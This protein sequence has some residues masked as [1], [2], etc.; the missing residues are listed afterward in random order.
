M[1]ENRRK[2]TVDSEACTIKLWINFPKYIYEKRDKMGLR[3]RKS[4]KI[5]P[6]VKV[7]LNK[8]SSSVT[9]GKRGAHYTINSKGKKTTSV[10]IP[11]TGLSYSTTSGGTTS[12]SKKSSATPQNSS[13]NG[14]K[15]GGCGTCLLWFFGIFLLFALFVYAWIPGIIGMIYFS[16]K[17]TDPSEKK[18]TLG[19]LGVVSVLS[20]LLFISS[21]GTPDLT[22]LT[23]NW[24][25]QEYDINETTEL[26]LVLTPIDAEIEKLV[27]SDNDIA[28]LD[29]KNGEAIISFKDEGTAT[30]Y[31]IANGSI[32]SNSATITVIDREAEEQREKEEAERKL[33]EEEAKRL[34]EEE[35]KKQAELEAQKQAEEEAQKQAELEAQKQAEEEAARLQAEQEAAQEPQ[36]EM[37]WIPQSG[38]KYH[39]RSTCSN[40]NNPRQVPISQA[41]SAGYQ[42]CKKCH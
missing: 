7:N 26:E 15:K 16:K 27:I 4:F 29:Y 1:V 41:E 20:F 40:M 38:S 28:T 39:N 13:D 34:A 23:V 31:F 19:I 6:G 5:A 35:A 2:P 33:A 10:G 25:Q 18:K 32:E 9:F 36:E 30:I 37:V 22:D 42:P 8:N 14:N 3:F 24:N 11:G 21:I 12:N 17:L